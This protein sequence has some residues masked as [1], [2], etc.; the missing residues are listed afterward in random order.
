MEFRHYSEKDY[1]ALCDFLIALN[2]TEKAHINWN[3]ARFEWMAEHPEFDKTAISSIGLWLDDGK[4]VGAAIY[5]M[6]FGEAFCAA[7]PAY[8]CLYPEILDYSYRALKDENGLG[9]AIRDDNRFEREA[10]EKA[11]FTKAEQTETVMRI[12][13]DKALSADL[14]DGFHFEELDPAREPYDFQWLLWQGFDHGTDKAEFERDLQ[15]IPRN[16]EHFDPY[17]SVTAVNADGEKA[18]YC[19]LWY[20]EKTDY[21][22]IEPV[23]VIPSHRGK[24]LAKAVIDEALSRARSRGAKQ[25]YVL[26]DMPFYERLGFTKTYHYT[27]YW[28]EGS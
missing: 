19:C 3:W 27:F 7:L 28:K 21:A 16:R 17:L 4:I 6:Y 9:I 8:S 22:Y 15:D 20:S 2:Q 13:L 11:G 18:A 1:Q 24:G 12:P 23:C 25:A 5:D 26:S 10:A 14:P